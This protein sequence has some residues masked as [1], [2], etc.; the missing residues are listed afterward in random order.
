MFVAA[1]E[2]SWGHGM[3]DSF[4]EAFALGVQVDLLPYALR[5]IARDSTSEV[6]PAGPW[7]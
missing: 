1:A 6:P 5:S 7:V 2:G 3:K 4:V